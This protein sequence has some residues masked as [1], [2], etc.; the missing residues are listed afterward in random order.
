[1]KTIICTLSLLLAISFGNAQT[2]S[3]SKVSI[4]YSS[5]EPGDRNYKVS[6]SIS[7]TDDVYTVNA[8][9]PG[10]RTEK[11]KNFLKDHLETKMKKVNS[12]YNWNYYNKDEMG[13]KVK[14]K[15]GKLSVFLDK[16]FVS[17][18]L[19]EDFIDMFSDLKEVIKG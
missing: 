16:E 8:K 10:S 14:L 12:S 6:I 17:V 15:R 1:M 3:N 11:L 5:D 19:I 18:D 9:F 4:N 2:S 7:N 13:Y